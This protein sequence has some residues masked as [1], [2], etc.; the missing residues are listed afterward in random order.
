[1]I[2]EKGF[3]GLPIPYKNFFIYPPLVRDI[4]DFEYLSIFKA[5]VLISE[6]EIEDIWIKENK[7]FS[8]LPSPYEYFYT[9]YKMS[10]QIA[11]IIKEG[12]FLFLKSNIEVLEDNILIGDIEDFQAVKKIHDLKVIFEQD[13]FDFQNIL[14]VLLGMKEIEKQ[15]PDEDPRV[16]KI[17]RATRK[18][19]RI[20]SKIRGRGTTLVNL[21]SAISCMGCGL[22][23]LN[24]GE[25]TY[26]SAM[27]ILQTFQKK[28]KYELDIQSLFAGADSKKIKPEYWI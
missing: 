5:L 11:A 6:E 20:V 27:E 22:N 25:I 17:K 4:I 14:R 23:P 16:K 18:R 24:I 10:E 12:F 1:M 15:D 26:V 13:F 3:L 7:D 2:K 19:E 9:H 8:L 28:E 21:F